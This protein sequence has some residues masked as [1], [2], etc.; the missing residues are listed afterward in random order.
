MLPKA[1]TSVRMIFGF[2]PDKNIFG[3]ILPCN[4]GQSAS[5]LTWVSKTNFRDLFVCWVW[6][7]VSDRRQMLR[8]PLLAESLQEMKVG[9]V[10]FGWRK[11]AACKSAE[12]HFEACLL[13]T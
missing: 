3:G 6:L 4:D 2:I 11:D 8:V 13:R 9:E 1:E 7:T 10:R 5:L 12:R